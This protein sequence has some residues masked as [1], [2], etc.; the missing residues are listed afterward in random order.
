ME[1]KPVF[2]FGDVTN[3]GDARFAAGV[4]ARFLGFNFEQDHP[5]H[6]NALKAHEI[7]QW[8][9]GPAYI[10]EY[11]HFDAEQIRNL[12]ELIP[13]DYVLFPFAEK[14]QV[15][16]ELPVPFI[17]EVMPG[18]EEDFLAMLDET[19]HQ[20]EL[21]QYADRRSDAVEQLLANLNY[22]EQLHK[23][24]QRKPLLLN[25]PFVPDNVVEAV[26]KAFPYG[27]ALQASQ[28]E[29][30]GFNDFGQLIDLVEAFEEL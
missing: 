18:E 1:H 15:M 23:L 10:A 20:P 13:F 9:S 11:R 17:M 7:T 26:Q 22:Q 6:I 30:V 8:L 12:L 14:P 5:Y 2:K 19:I 3:L 25:M 28:E 27:I 21:V 4:G 16:P 24:N 29:K